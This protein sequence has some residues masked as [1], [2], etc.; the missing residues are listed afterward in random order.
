MPKTIELHKMYADNISYSITINPSNSYQYFLLKRDRLKKLV[1]VH[2]D[3]LNTVKYC[4]LTLFAE[5]SK[6]GRYHYHG[7]V[8]IINSLYFHLYDLPCLEDWNNIKIDT[9]NDPEVWSTY[10]KK[11]VEVMRHPLIRAP[12]L[13]PPEAKLH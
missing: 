11:N 6:S 3:K 9:I 1:E 8:T 13:I 2:T 5:L 10:C 7:Y 4:K 12:L